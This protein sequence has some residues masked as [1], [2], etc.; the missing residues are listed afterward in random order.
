MQAYTVLIGG[1]PFDTIYANSLADAKDTAAT[2]DYGVSLDNVWVRDDRPVCV[3]NPRAFIIIAEDS[4]TGETV[5]TVSENGYLKFVLYTAYSGAVKANDG[6]PQRYRPGEAE[7][8][9]IG[10]ARLLLS[11]E[12]KRRGDKPEEQFFARNP[13]IVP[14]AFAT[15]YLARQNEA[16]KTAGWATIPFY[17]DSY[18]DARDLLTRIRTADV[19]KDTRG[20]GAGIRVIRGEFYVMVYTGNI[21]GM[22]YDLEQARFM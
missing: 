21:R 4:V 3:G 5:F 11:N 1:V 13:R 18:D 2:R 14:A 17:C 16:A 8:H 6:L 12:M 22:I 20:D 10:E 19:L 15:E 7:R 9:T